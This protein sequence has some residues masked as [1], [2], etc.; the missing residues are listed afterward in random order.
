DGVAG[1]RLLVPQGTLARETLVR[2]LRE[3]GAA[4]DAITVYETVPADV[5]APALCA[6]LVAGELDALTFASP[7]AAQRFAGCLDDA[8][9]AAARRA[10]VAAIGETTASALR[11]L[12]LPPHVI[13][14]EASAQSLVEA[15][16]RRFAA[17]RTGGTA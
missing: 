16:A 13:P 12:G 15:L 1:R 8:A 2:G 17:S 10:V 5:D 4:V 11:A 3:A 7:S 14:D 6:A 9:L